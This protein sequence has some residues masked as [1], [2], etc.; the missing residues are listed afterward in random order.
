MENKT[1]KEIYTGDE[2]EMITHDLAKSSDYLAYLSENNPVDVDM[3]RYIMLQTQSI[4][5]RIEN[6][7]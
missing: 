6:E 5:Y 1:I 7:D 2:L 4:I 3:L